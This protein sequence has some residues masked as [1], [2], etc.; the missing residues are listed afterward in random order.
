MDINAHEQGILSLEAQIEKLCAIAD[1]IDASNGMTKAL[2]LEAMEV[3]P[4]FCKNVPL[5]YYTKEPSIAQH[6]VALEELETGIIA[7]IAAAT[8]AMSVMIYKFYKWI[9]GKGKSGATEYDLETTT[10]TIENAVANKDEADSLMK[11]AEDELV[12]SQSVSNPKKDADKEVKAS[13]IDELVKNYINGPGKDSELATA[14]KELDPLLH[15]LLSNGEYANEMNRAEPNMKGVLDIIAGLSE[16]YR[17]ISDTIKLLD[18]SVNVT[19]NSFFKNSFDSLMEKLH[20]KNS[21][22]KNFKFALA[23]GQNIALSVLA[24]GMKEVEEKVKGKTTN[25]LLVF[26]KINTRFGNA[27]MHTNIIKLLKDVEK[28]SSTEESLT[29]SLEKLKE[30]SEKLKNRS[31][32]D[33]ETIKLVKDIG[34]ALKDLREDTTSCLKFIQVIVN[35]GNVVRKIDSKVISLQLLVIKVIEAQVR[36]NTGNV[37]DEL[38]SLHKK[39]SDNFKL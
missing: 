3:M 31:D 27:I 12:K 15:D 9:F 30:E 5:A 8:I 18:T 17:L 1:G 36:N 34:T 32:S 24:S 28:L 26:S 16:R 20:S 10:A 23:K 11:K 21:I 6:R 39:L 35:Y 33:E 19:T 13:N 22:A 37:S 25:E 38:K 4:S 7:L 2:A 29:S 14:L